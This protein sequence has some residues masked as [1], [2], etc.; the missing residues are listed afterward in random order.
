[1]LK[2]GNIEIQLFILP[3]QAGQNL[4]SNAALGEYFRSFVAYGTI[5]FALIMNIK[6]EKQK[7]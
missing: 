5:S 1:M 3:P 4:F 7:V 2:L 6:G